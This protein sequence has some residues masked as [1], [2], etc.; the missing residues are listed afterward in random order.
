[1]PISKDC[2]VSNLGHQAFNM[3]S[4]CM[5]WSPSENRFIPS[6]TIPVH[7]YFENHWNVNDHVS[8]PQ[9]SEKVNVKRRANK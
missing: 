1:M 5:L 4:L 3:Y 2:V 8:C 7:S 6:P 9:G